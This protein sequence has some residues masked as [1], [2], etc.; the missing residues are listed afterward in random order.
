[1]S[2]PTTQMPISHWHKQLTLIS[3]SLLAFLLVYS[4]SLLNLFDFWMKSGSYGHGI[5]IPPITMYLIWLKKES[6]ANYQAKPQPLGLLPLFILSICWLIAIETNIQTIERIALISLLPALAWT[7]LGNKI[8]KI[9][10]FPLLYLFI[11]APIWDVI[12]T[13]LQNFTA[14][15]SYKLIQLTGLPILLEGKHITIPAGNF[16]VEKACGGLR[17]F[18]SAAAISSLYAH[19]NLDSLFNQAKFVLIALIG[20]VLLNWARVCII[21]MIGQI[22]EMQHPLVEDHNTLGWWLFA[23]GLFPLFYYGSRLQK[24]ERG[25]KREPIILVTHRSSIRPL[26]YVSIFTTISISLAPLTLYLSNTSTKETSDSSPLTFNILAPWKELTL[27]ENSWTPTFIGATASLIKTY[28]DNSSTVKLYVAHYIK[29][30]QGAELINEVNSLYSLD[31][32]RSTESSLRLIQ[33]SDQ[34]TMQ[35][36]EIQLDNSSLQ[37]RVIWYWYRIGTTNTTKPLYAKLLEL[38]KLINTQPSASVIAISI[39]NEVSLDNAREKLSSFIS[40]N[41]QEIIT[42]TP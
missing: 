3:F 31:K 27:S 25:K 40:D 1:M 30:S 20:A 36:Q 38:Q 34:N 29:Q 32:W 2:P 14:L 11:A 12:A 5:L 18:I 28:S 24:R 41:Y 17:F 10:L 21:I 4:N 16:L 13:P 39:D 9:I 15:A 19:L 37:T 7:L 22:T 6:L 42:S 33:L 8:T 26:I 35:V 23:A